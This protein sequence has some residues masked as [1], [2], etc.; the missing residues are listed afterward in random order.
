MQDGYWMLE[1]L[2]LIKLNPL[3]VI[4]LLH[5]AGAKSLGMD[6]GRPSL[7]LFLLVY[8]LIS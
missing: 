3:R 1:D 8:S 4:E 2:R 6:C 5:R 7:G